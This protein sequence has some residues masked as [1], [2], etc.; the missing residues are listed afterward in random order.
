[1]EP[2]SASGK[3]REAEGRDDSPPASKRARIVPHIAITSDADRHIPQTAN[4]DDKGLLRQVL[5]ATYQIGQSHCAVEPGIDE[6]QID[7]ITG[8]LVTDHVHAGGGAPPDDDEPAY[9][10]VAFSFPHTCAFR[11]SMVDVISGINAA[12]IPRDQIIVKMETNAGKMP[13]VRVMINVYTTTRKPP[14]REDNEHIF[15]YTQPSTRTST[16]VPRR[17]PTT[18]APRRRPNPGFVSR[19]G[20][21]IF[22]DD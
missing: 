8:V 17:T 2:T 22:G 20:Q 16:P 6:A 15:F 11:G 12:R 18:P 3:K 9:Y 5:V 10:T 13:R 21:L 1:M 7:P 19:M 14:L 4:E